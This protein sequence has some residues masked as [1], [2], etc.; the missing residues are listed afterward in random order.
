MYF[1]LQA[2]LVARDGNESA[3][4]GDLAWIKEDLLRREATTQSAF[5]LESSMDGRGL[6]GFNGHKVRHN[7]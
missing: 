5:L 2:P 6:V 1:P 7:W 4:N 3:C